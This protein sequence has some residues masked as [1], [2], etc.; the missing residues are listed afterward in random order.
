[1]RPNGVDATRSRTKPAAS[2]SAAKSSAERANGTPPPVNAPYNPDVSNA[3]ISLIAQT[4]LGKLS[5]E[6][7]TAQMQAAAEKVMEK[8]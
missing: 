5:V 1:M 7:G 3:V 6:E 8:Y 4:I 2:A